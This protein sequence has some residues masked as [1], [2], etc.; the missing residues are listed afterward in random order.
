MLKSKTV[1]TVEATCHNLDDLRVALREA[2]DLEG[3][4]EVKLYIELSFPGIGKQRIELL[5]EVPIHLE[6]VEE[7]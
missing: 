6:Y 5:E 1:E 2:D 3:E 4:G 7:N